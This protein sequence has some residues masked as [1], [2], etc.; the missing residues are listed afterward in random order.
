MNVL[1]SSVG[2]R[3]YLVDYFKEALRGQGQVVATNTIAETTGM[4]AADVAEVV[5]PANESGFID[6]LLDVCRR[7]DV[8]LLCSLHDWVTPYIA[9]HKSRFQAEGIITVVPDPEIIDICLDKYKTGQFANSIGL[10]FPKSFIELE[11]ALAAVNSREVDFPLILKPRWG[12]GSIAMKMVHTTEELKSAY[13]WIHSELSS[14]GLGYL[15]GKHQEHQVLI[16]QFVKGR[17]YGVDV[18]N[19]LHGG[20]A[21]CFVKHKFAMRCGET[22]AAETVTMPEIE[23]YCRRIAEATKHPGIMDADF[24]LSED[25]TV[26]LLEMN[27]RFGGGYPFSHMAGANI[28]AALIAWAKGND[29]EPGWLQ[30]NPNI[31][32]YKDIRLIRTN[33]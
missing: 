27:P 23:E 12:Q 10:P 8:R 18:V 2:R 26:Y 33:L 14:S 1:L 15:A 32:S 16:Q 4:Y 31:K 24:F 25:G 17:E 30:V 28:P 13:R 3:S 19:D 29:P 21:A 22:D 9:S 7:Y 5:P 6:A 11:N 20:F